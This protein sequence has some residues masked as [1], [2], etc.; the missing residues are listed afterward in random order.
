MGECFYWYRPT[1]V[2][3]DQG[4]LNGCVCV[5]VCAARACVRVCTKT[6]INWLTELCE[7][8]RYKQANNM[9]GGSKK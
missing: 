2:V 7:S 1:R 8:K 3:L 5:C 9:Q 6:V 4:P